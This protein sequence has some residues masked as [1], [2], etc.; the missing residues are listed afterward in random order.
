MK[1]DKECIP[2]HT[3]DIS[4]FVRQQNAKKTPT[5]AQKVE[6]AV[7]NSLPAWKQLVNGNDFESAITSRCKCRTTE[8][9]R[10]F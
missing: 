10:K 5:L 6:K 1:S 8:G 9:R 3:V 7:I 4:A 2:L